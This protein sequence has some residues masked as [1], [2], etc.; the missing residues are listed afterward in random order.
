[1]KVEIENEL[2]IS[3][4]VDTIR[5]RAHEAGLFGRVARKKPYVNKVNQEKRLK[6]AKEMLEKP[7]SFWE[8]V[9][10]SDESKFNLF[11]S[12][13][14]AMVWR[15]PREEFDLK[16]TVPTVKRGGGSVMVWG[17][18]TRRGVGKLCVLDR[19]MDRFYYRDILEQNLLPSI[20]HFKFGQQYHF[21][22]DND[23]KHTSRLVEDWLKQKRI[24]TLPWPSFSP[25]LNPIENLW[26]DLERRVKKHQPRNLQ[27]LELQLTQER[28]NIE[29]SVLKK[30]ADSVPSRL[31]EC[32][33]MKVYP[34]KY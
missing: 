10:W 29:L 28:N 32:V 31:Y 12:D 1:M 25:D 30:L 7:S 16:C 14:K 33:K 23:P 9:I 8:S 34:T 5:N 3:L 19:I 27:E 4:H 21:M 13:G 18:F 6:F 17:C 15:T 11:G 20:D 22:H 2:G 24:Q 26:D